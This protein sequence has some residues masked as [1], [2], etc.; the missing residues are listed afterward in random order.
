MENKIGFLDED[1]NSKSH[2][3]VMSFMV[4]WLLVGIDYAILFHSYYSNRQ[5][6]TIFIWIFLGINF[7]FLIAI[8]YPKYLQKILELG[9]AKFQQVKDK[10]SE[11]LPND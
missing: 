8:F 9:Q 7:L 5:W 4:F 1:L 3:R 10:I 2:I 11:K 6:D